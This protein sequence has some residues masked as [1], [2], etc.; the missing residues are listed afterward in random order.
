MSVLTH[1]SSNCTLTL[2]GDFSTIINY[3]ILELMLMEKKTKGEKKVYESHR[4][5]IFK[6]TELKKQQHHLGVTAC[7]YIGG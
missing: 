7:S 6:V 1:Y 4:D 2:S 5:F 3:I